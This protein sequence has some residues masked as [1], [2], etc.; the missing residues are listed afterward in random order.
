[1]KSQD[2]IVTIVYRKKYDLIRRG[3]E[4]KFLIINSQNINT[5]KLNDCFFQLYLGKTY[6]MGLEICVGNSEDII[7]GI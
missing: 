2:Q 7:V 5:L 3:I 1:M 6:F 4:P